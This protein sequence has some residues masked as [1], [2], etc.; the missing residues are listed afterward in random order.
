LIIR[1][2]RAGNEFSV[3]LRRGEPRFQVKLPG[4]R[5]IKG[6]RH[7][8]HDPVRKVECLVELPGQIN[9]H[10]VQ[11]PRKLWLA[12]DQLLYLFELMNAEYAEGVTAM[13]SD[14]LAKQDE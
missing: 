2:V 3:A 5:V 11:A 1:A 6:S 12:D 14:L 10:V 4:G 9:H 8:I 7:D 13:F